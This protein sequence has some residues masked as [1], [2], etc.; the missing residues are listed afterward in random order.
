MSTIEF[1]RISISVR[2]NERINDREESKGMIADVCTNPE[3]GLIVYCTS[4]GRVHYWN[5]VCGWMKRNRLR[6]RKVSTNSMSIDWG[7]LELVS[8]EQRLDPPVN[9]TLNMNGIELILNEN[10]S[11]HNRNKSIT[12]CDYRCGW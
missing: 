1:R 5:K 7:R 11:H 2:M 12:L 8:T 4:N 3:D 10:Q 6:T 9:D